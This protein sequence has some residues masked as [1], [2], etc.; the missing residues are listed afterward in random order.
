MSSLTSKLRVAF[1]GLSATT[2]IFAGLGQTEAFAG[3]HHGKKHASKSHSSSKSTNNAAASYATD[4][5]TPQNAGASASA[6]G[7]NGPVA[8]GDNI[9]IG[10]IIIA[11]GNIA[12]GNGGA[13]GTAT[14]TAG[15][16][17]AAQIDLAAN[18]A[19]PIMN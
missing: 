12:S 5:S 18:N 8:A 15:A 2:M 10:N 11:C 4:K 6:N 9:C 3:K 13:G 14:S 7:G 17:L 19:V 16:N 1:V